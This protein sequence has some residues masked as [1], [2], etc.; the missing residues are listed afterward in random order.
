MEKLATKLASY[1]MNK[2]I[3]DEKDYDGY[4]YGIQT[5]MELLIC[6]VVS[7]F[8]AYVH[9]VFIEFLIIVSVF[10]PL[11]AY[12]CGVHMKHFSSCFICSVILVIYGPML[13]THLTLSKWVFLLLCIGIIL[14]IHKL[15]FITTKYQCDQKEVIFFAR[16]RKKVLL[17]VAVLL[18][19]CMFFAPE[20][21]R[22][23]FYALLVALC[24]VLF[25]IARI[26][27]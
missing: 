17:Y 3:I 5:G 25:E 26:R 1:I 8:L 20:L 16:Q 2:G 10:L 15:A 13:A 7:A 4:H 9:D 11:R 27:T 14:L 19:L 22:Q 23:I 18:F 24:S 12:I 21:M 6:L